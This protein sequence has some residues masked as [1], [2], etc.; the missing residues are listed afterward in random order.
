M[1][2]RT[3]QV[4]GWLGGAFEDLGSVCDHESKVIRLVTY[5]TSLS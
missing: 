5:V 4:R 1:T 3:I 2:A